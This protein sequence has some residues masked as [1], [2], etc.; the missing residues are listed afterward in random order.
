MKQKLLAAHNAGT[1]EKPYNFF[2]KIGKPIY[3]CQNKSIEELC[4]AGVR[5]F[6]LRVKYVNDRLYIAHGL[7]LLDKTL[8]GAIRDIYDNTPEGEISYI[9]VTYEGTLPLELSNSFKY[10]IISILDEFISKC[11]L[12]QIAIKKPEWK[13][14]LSN[15]YDFNGFNADYI[16]IVGWKCLFPFPKFWNKFVECETRNTDNK[17]S[18]RDFI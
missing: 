14:L 16:K 2:A 11:K 7:A 12:Y 8:Y 5:L 18:M 3:K 6:D 13:V 4:K 15:K 10:D 17:F 9:M 1:G